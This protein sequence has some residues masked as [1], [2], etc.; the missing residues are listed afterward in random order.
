MEIK[1]KVNLEMLDGELWKSRNRKF[2]LFK[3]IN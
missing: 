1:K 3:F 2:R